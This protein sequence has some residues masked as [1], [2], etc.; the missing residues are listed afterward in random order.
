[1]ALIKNMHLKGE[2]PH[3]HGWVYDVETGEIRVVE[4]GRNRE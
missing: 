1:M 2:V 4:D 3:V